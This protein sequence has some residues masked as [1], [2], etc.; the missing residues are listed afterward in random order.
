[1]DRI[2]MRVLLVD[3]DEDDYIITRDLLASIEGQVFQLDWVP[4]CALAIEAI[5]RNEHDVYIVDYRLGDGSGLDLVRD[6]VKNGCRAPMILLTGQGHHEVDVA[7]MRVGAADYL[8]KGQISAPLLERSIRHAIERSHALEALRRSEE[9]FRLLIENSYDIIVVLES[10]GAVRYNS[11]SV[12]RIL[13][14]KH[15]E[16]IGANLFDYVHP[17]DS[18]EAVRTFKALLSKPGFS[19]PIEFR[20]LHSDGSWHFLESVGNNLLNDQGVA[21]IVFN[22]RDITERK[23][24]EQAL[25]K[26]Q[27]SLAKAQQ[28]ARLGN[29]EL[30]LITS[31]LSWSDEIREIYGAVPETTDRHILFWDA[32]HPD[33]RSRVTAAFEA[34]MSGKRPYSIDHR[35]ILPDGS[36]RIVNEQAEFVFDE[37]GKPVRAVGT[38][39]DITERKR[40]EE[41]LRQSELQYRNLF[42]SAIDPI[43]IFE[44]ENEI[45]LEVN[46]QACETYGFAR[47]ELIGMSLKKLTKNVARGEQ[48]VYKLM[49]NRTYRNFE[50]VHFKKNGQPMDMLASSAVIDYKGKEAVLSIHRDMTERKRLQQQLI[51]SE[52]MAA[53]GQL[54]SGVA[55]EL[56]NPLTSV[57]GYTHLLLQI[58]SLDAQSRERLNIISRE[59][60]RTRRIVTNLLSFSRQNK[61]A[62]IEVDINDLLKRTIEL[63]AYELRV[64]NIEVRTDF[65][66]I[67]R[68]FG[69]EHQ[70]QQVFLNIIINGEQA[71][72]SEK[73]AGELAIKTEVSSKDGEQTVL[74]TIADDGPGIPAQNL[75]KVFD[76]FFTIKRI[77]KG[78]GLGLSITYGIVKEH[79]GDIRA[80]NNPGGGAR[81]VVELPLRGAS[82][83]EV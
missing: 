7:A 70:L 75:D 78:S 36:E 26:S 83:S 60:D 35:I 28:I 42:E 67:P 61:S 9:R 49:R 19:P 82:E 25:L 10:D 13:G 71:I 33:D 64:N 1:M 52:K 27:Q 56:N 40:M 79:G 45:I 8:V 3:D 15:G 12:E 53:L 39:Q 4:S 6:A 68:V 24:A 81:F 57:I 55:H 17:D 51:Q 20:L 58:P 69:D 59:A 16:L 30:D 34:A 43:L 50:T 48:Q 38:V 22:S 32:V 74:V 5:A 77:G 14:Y 66:E 72:R 80:E 62:C 18:A 21:G 54:V 76:P 2:R 46:N 11:P 41:A 29:W 63:R 73:S 44:P 47:E 31:E 23:Q 37:N 65:G